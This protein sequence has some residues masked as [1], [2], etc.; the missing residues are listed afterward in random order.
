VSPLPGPYARIVRRWRGGEQLELTLEM[1]TRLETRDGRSPATADLH[2]PTE[3]LLFVGPRLM[4]AHEGAGASFLSSAPPASPTLLLPAVLAAG[5][6]VPSP[7]VPSDEGVGLGWREERAGPPTSK[8]T[9]LPLAAA[10]GLPSGR[11][12]MWL[13]YQTAD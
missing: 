13:R 12:A 2:E 1:Q 5:S 9:L 11:A 4:A 7:L 6:T 8:V 10:T 3:A